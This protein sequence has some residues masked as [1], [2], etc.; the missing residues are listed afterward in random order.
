MK[1][2]LKDIW[3]FIEGTADEHMGAF[4]SQS[5]FFLFLSFFPLINLLAVIPT[6]LP[7]SKEQVMEVIYYVVPAQFENFI[8]GL[9]KQH[10]YAWFR[11]NN[12]F[13]CCDC[14]LVGG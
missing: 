1:N 13:L 4:S 2:R 10:V 11:I 3:R 8:S 5:A 6:F 7:I 9:V 12:Y 14:S